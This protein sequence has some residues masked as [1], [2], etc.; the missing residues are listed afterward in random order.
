VLFEDQSN[1]RLITDEIVDA[2]RG[3]QVTSR[4]GNILS[5]EDGMIVTEPAHE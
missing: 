4:L 2:E 1:A 3:Q 5:E